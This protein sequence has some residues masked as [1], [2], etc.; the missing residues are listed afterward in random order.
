MR[1]QRRLPRQLAILRMGRMLG[2]RLV[3]ILFRRGILLSKIEVK[4][5]AYEART[6][7]KTLFHMPHGDRRRE[8]EHG[9]LVQ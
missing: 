8:C 7:V 1:G 5:H 4:Q 2:W 6:E 9:V 3:M